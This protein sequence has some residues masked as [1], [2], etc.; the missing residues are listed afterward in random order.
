MSSRLLLILFRLLLFFTA[1]SPSSSSFPSFLIFSFSRSGSSFC[2]Y[3]SSSITFSFSS[4]F[5]FFSCTLPLT[6]PPLLPLSDPSLLYPPSIPR[7]PSLLSLVSFPLPSPRSVFP[8][9][10]SLPLLSSPS[11]PP[12][13]LPF[14]PWFH[15]SN[16]GL[17][18]EPKCWFL[19][20]AYFRNGHRI[21]TLI[22]IIEH[23]QV[24][25]NVYIYIC[26]CIL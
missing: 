11:P 24:H 1:F 8:S 25:M 3:L 13:S 18:P 26:I 6:F 20:A 10:G 23:I 12:L 17:H 21:N 9:S 19:M 7:R 16:S 4:S 15:H 5:S 14:L 22:H 2:S